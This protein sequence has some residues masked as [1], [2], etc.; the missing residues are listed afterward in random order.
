MKIVAVGIGQCGCNIVDEFYAFNNY[1]KSFFN[2]RIE[3][4]TD[5]FAVNTDE[6]DLV[7]LRQIPQDRD[8]RIVIGSMTTFGHGVGKINVD[9]SKIMKDS[10]SVIVENIM[11]SERFHECDG[12]I[13][14]ASGGG[15]T[16]S[17][18]I[19]WLLKSLKERIDKPIYAIV[20]LPFAY[21][22]K[23]EASYAVINTGT[24]LQMVS[25]YAD[26][27]FLLDNERYGRANV[28]LAKNFGEINRDMVSNFYDL[29]CAGE[30]T[31]Q[32]YV[33]SKVIDAGDIK[34]SLGGITAIGRG[35]IGL[36]AF[37]RWRREHFR[38]EVKE[39]G[40]V[41]GAL[42]Q[43]ENNLSLNAD[44]DN[45]RKILALFTAP[46]DIITLGIVEEVY[47]FL[48]DRAPRAVVRMGDYPRRKRE[49]SMTL[50]ASELTEVPRVER[51]Y[52][53]AGK[54]VKKQEEINRKAAKRMKKLQE[55]GKNLPSLEF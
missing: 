30:E 41:G 45:A 1:A 9:A 55:A 51:L 2:R 31:K 48:Q 43:A 22:E 4:L 35:E 40:S 20:V 33:G 38:K 11:N 34:E 49:I 7:A 21:E 10:R 52:R 16:G 54:L 26:A 47:S 50:I 8:H 6:V 37:Y 53:H 19:G 42:R 29:F 44:L 17:G 18:S 3:I 13:A 39:R 28:S 25:R 5:A 12:V 23:G 27:V 24:C 32:K 36:S 15:G 14:V 46:K